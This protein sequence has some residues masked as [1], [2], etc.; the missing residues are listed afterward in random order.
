MDD[1]PTRILGVDPGSRIMG[2]AIL[3]ISEDGLYY[4]WKEIKSIKVSGPSFAERL[5]SVE[6]EVRR[7]L[8]QYNPVIIAWEA[9]FYSVGTRNANVTIQLGKVVGIIEH[10][11]PSCPWIESGYECQPSSSRKAIGAGNGNYFLLREILA[12]EFPE[13]ARDLWE[14]VD[15]DREHKKQPKSKI[16]CDAVSAMVQAYAIACT[17]EMDFKGID[18][19]YG[20]VKSESRSSLAAPR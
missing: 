13:K 9:P 16:G 12:R 20:Q 14:G 2:I 7:V 11:L 1:A 15:R 8:C 3:E 18:R 17:K 19:V 5:Y 4:S 6:I 10:Q